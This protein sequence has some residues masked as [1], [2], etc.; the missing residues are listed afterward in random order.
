MWFFGRRKREKNAR[1]LAASAHLCETPLAA[2]SV[3]EEYLYLAT[4]QCRCGGHYEAFNHELRYCK[5]QPRDVIE[6]R[7]VRCRSFYC[8][9]YDIAF[10]FGKQPDEIDRHT[11]SELLD[12][13]DWSHHGYT[14]LHQCESASGERH[15]QL[16]QDAVWA[17]EEMLKFYP[18][19]GQLP[20]P[21]SFFNHRAVATSHL[22]SR[23]PRC[24]VDEAVAAA[25]SRMG[26]I[27]RG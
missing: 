15:E 27:D 6:A 18:S 23:Y 3:R 24:L 4:R 5:G 12:V 8:V 21:T 16:L 14:C 25:R 22:R 17:F 1:I 10:F 2:H 20:F 13:M 7:C 19:N 9:V 26:R 11:P